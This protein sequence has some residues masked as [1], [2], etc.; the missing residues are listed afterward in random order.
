LL[1][2]LWEFPGGKVRPGETHKAALVREVA[3]EL[4]IGIRVGVRLVS[5]DHAYTHFRITLHVYAAE[6]LSGTPVPRSHTRIR[7]VFPGHFDRYAF[8]AATLKA[9]QAL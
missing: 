1:G 3:E 9:M 8:P 5:V 6:H 4:G 7:W 2:G